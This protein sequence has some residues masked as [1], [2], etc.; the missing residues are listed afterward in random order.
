MLVVDV[1][2]DSLVVVFQVDE[3]ELLKGLVV[4]DEVAILDVVI[5]VLYVDI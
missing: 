1:I 3:V 5:V 2:E 4:D